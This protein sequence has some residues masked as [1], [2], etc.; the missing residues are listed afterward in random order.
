MLNIES[1]MTSLSTTRPIFH[2][3]A[4]FQHALAWEIREQ[5]PTAKIRLERRLD[6]LDASSSKGRYL[7]LWVEIHGQ[8]TAIELKYQTR[9]LKHVHDNEPFDLLNQGAED[10]LGYDF[11]KD[12]T[13][14][15]QFVT[16]NPGSEGHA[17]LLSN[18]HLWSY[19][20]KTI[21]YK[22]DAFRIHEGRELS[23]VLSWR[24][25]LTPN[26]RSSPLVLRNGYKIQWRD[27]TSIGGKYGEFKYLWMKV[28]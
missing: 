6:S 27:F 5:N 22:K 2:S 23:G 16:T 21:E 11:I 12:I 9:A 19:G 26:E 28:G 7:D 14:L 15:E 18:E 24:E 4:D 1:L 20:P 17:I 25:P 10:N 13:R 8:I 3:E